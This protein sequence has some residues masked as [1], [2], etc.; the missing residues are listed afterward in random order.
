MGKEQL[1]EELLPGWFEGTLGK[2]DRQKVERWKKASVGN[3]KYFEE[4][5]EVWMQTERLRVMQKYNAQKALDKV[6][7][8]IEKSGKLQFIELFKRV[9]AILVLPIMFASIYLYIQNPKEE[10]V[11]THR[12][13]LT[14]GAGMRSEYVLPDGTKVF[15]NSNTTLSYPIAF[16]AT[17]REVVLQGEAY[18][19]VAQNKEKPFVVNTGKIQI[20]V[21]GTE[22][23]ASN[24]ASEKL[25]EIVLVEGSVNLCQCNNLGQRNVIQSMIPGDKA[26]LEDSNNRLYLEKIE[27]AKYIAWKDGVLM[28]RDDSMEEV[29]R[30]L[31][32]WYNVDIML[33]GKSLDDYVYT[34][35]FKDESLIQVLDLLKIS[36]PIDY[37]IVQ[38]ERKTD[39]SFSKMKIEII[40]R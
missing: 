34:A 26:V 29:V 39:N 18:F 25:T 38:R 33:S 27:V 35:T 1:I 14:T 20:E 22:F 21:T 40:Q 5:E 36:A 11:G 32:R 2:D 9:A 12:Y 17:T 30:R 23:K 3:K 6:N 28:F 37:R 7:Q 31:N 24:Y 4:F 8:K 15:L 16:S 19:D 13:T 10:N